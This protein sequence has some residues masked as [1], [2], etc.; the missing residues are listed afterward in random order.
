MIDEKKRKEEIL[1]AF[2]EAPD[3]VNFFT[4]ELI[5]QEQ[6]MIAELEKQRNE[7]LEIVKLYYNHAKNNMQICGI[8]TKAK[9][10]IK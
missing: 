8:N 5:K 4:A 7:L 6:A 9:E 1:E 3:I 10:L 2:D